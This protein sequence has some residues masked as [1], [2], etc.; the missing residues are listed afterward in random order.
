MC[1]RHDPAITEDLA[2][3]FECKACYAGF[4]TAD[5]HRYVEPAIR[6]R[7]AVCVENREGA[8]RAVIRF[9]PAVDLA[10][11]IRNSRSARTKI[12][13]HGDHHGLSYFHSFQ[14]R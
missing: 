6:C 8:S 1:C 4:L 9:V 2:G 13:I 5:M 3:A 12:Q 11:R 10:K 14:L 7:F